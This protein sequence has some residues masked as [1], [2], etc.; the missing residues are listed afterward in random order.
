MNKIFI[1]G[2]VP[3]FDNSCHY[4]NTEDENKAFFRG[5]LNVKGF[6]RDENGK[7]KDDIVEFRAFRKNAQNLAKW[8][9][10]GQ[11]FE[12]EGYIAPSQPMLKDGQAVTTSDGKKVYTGPQV[13]INRIDFA[14]NYAERDNNG[15][16][17]AAAIN[18]T[19]AAPAAVDPMAMFGNN[20]PVGVGAAAAAPSSKGGSED[21]GANWPF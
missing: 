6:T 16:S 10:K 21:F 4:S 19:A 9:R 18:M 14:R 5:S 17:S 15:S 11:G 2:I 8:W 7:Y 3:S 20:E 1:S 13:I 12:L